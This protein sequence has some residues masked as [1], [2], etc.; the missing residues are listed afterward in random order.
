MRTKLIILIIL[1][2]ILF[3]F[4]LGA[5]S[6]WDP[7]EPRQAIMA[8]E[9]DQRGD[10]IH[11]YLNGVPYLEKPPFYSW[12]IILAAKISG[13]LDEFAS[14]APSA[15]AALLF[16]VVTF[17][18]G[19]RLGD[20]RAGFLSGLVLM[21]NYQFLSNA[22]ESVMDMTF[23]FLIGL[24][25]YL[26]FV[27]LEKDR[28]FLFVLSFIP[29]A[30][31]IL[32]KGPAGLVIPAGIIFFILLF[33]KAMK[34]YFIPLALGCILAAAIASVWFILAGES[35][36]KEFIFHQN[37]TRYTK[38]FDHFESPWYYFHKLF[39]NFMPWSLLLPFALFTAFRKRYLL[40][41]T[42]FILIFLFFEFSQSKRA[43]Y[44]LPAYPA[45]ALLV[46]LFLRDSWDTLV[47][48][49]WTNHLLKVFAAL[50]VLIPVAAI[51][52]INVMPPED[53]AVFRNGPGSLYIY[54]A[55]LFLAGSS[56]LTM[57]FKRK[58]DLALSSLMFF[59]IFTGFFYSAYYM[60]LVDRTSKSLTLITDPLGD[61]KRTKKIYT[62]GFN[63]AGIIFYV[64]KPVTMLR[65]INEIKTFERDILLI[66]EERPAMHL[67]ETIE[68]YLVPIKRVKYEKEHYIFYVR[69]HG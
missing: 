60:P 22:R 63:S 44:L 43:I 1:A 47:E 25:V 42:W 29:G 24:A 68:K 39:F 21:T 11:P 20:E 64:G 61:H 56:F 23:A 18:L 48:K 62:F 49:G 6:L 26:A 67:K 36:I 17:L 7:D 40:P 33:K 45:L 46:G 57:L 16:V 12:M 55:V 51:I 54:L 8:R 15:L 32:T 2:G 31:A 30:F 35:Y 37:L 34:R 66:V 41:L 5:T 28:R 9:M 69:D 58:K 19:C 38:A 27:S 14:R 53:V 50:L 4:N 52:A 10:Y 65:D 13:T 3:F 59:L